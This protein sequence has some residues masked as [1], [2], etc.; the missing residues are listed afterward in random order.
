MNTPTLVAATPN[1]NSNAQAALMILLTAQ[2]QAQSGESSL[3]QNPQVVG[4]LQNLV[5]PSS[6]QSEVSLNEIL[7]NPTL[8]NVFSQSRYGKVGNAPAIPSPP[9]KE[10]LAPPLKDSSPTP[11]IVANNLNNL[12]N[13]QNLS[14]LLGSLTSDQTPGAATSVSPPTSAAPSSGPLI[15]SQPPPP[16]HS[17]QR[18][19]M[20]VPGQRPVL[21]GDPPSSQ[22]GYVPQQRA[23]LHQMSQPGQYGGG[24]LTAPASAPT[25]TPGLMYPPGMPGMSVTGPPPAAGF[26]GLPPRPALQ[27]HG[28]AAAAYYHQPAAAAHVAAAQAQAAQAQQNAVYMAQQQQQALATQQYYLQL[29]QQQQAQQQA[30]QQLHQAQQQALALAAAANNPMLTSTPYVPASPQPNS[31]QQAPVG[32]GPG[33]YVYATPP[34]AGNKRKLPIPPSPEQSPDGPYI[35]QHSQGLGGHYADSY[36][37]KKRAKFS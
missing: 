13:T 14:E 26:Y 32:T 6:G 29:Q 22:P 16:T 10:A 5:D 30:Q 7:S 24:L 1:L 21:L 20:A 8:S 36:W 2:M 35:G 33:S 19:P 34:S 25:S 9:L 3:L 31:V 15:H 11:P 28:A 4:I 17:T 12:L 23:P 37:A 27:Q 18:R